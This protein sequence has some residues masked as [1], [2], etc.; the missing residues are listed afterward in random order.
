MMTAVQIEARRENINRLIESA[1]STFLTVTFVKKDQTVRDMNVQL[2]AGRDE[3]AGDAASDS[4]KQAVET[5]KA[6]HPNLRAVYD[7]AKSAWRSINLDTVL[8]IKVRGTVYDVGP[9]PS[10]A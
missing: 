9:L 10:A 8:R 5:R 6:N 3:L 4:A 7:I 2:F 1:G